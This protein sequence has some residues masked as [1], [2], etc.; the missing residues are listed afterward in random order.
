MV[1]TT[2]QIDLHHMLKYTNEHQS[3][4]YIYIY[5]YKYVGGLCRSL[6][7]YQTVSELTNQTIDV[8]YGSFSFLLRCALR[9]SFVTTIR[10]N[11]ITSYGM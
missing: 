11:R 9:E 7:G 5:I 6:T 1:E 10:D 4:V 3:A 2:N 8:F